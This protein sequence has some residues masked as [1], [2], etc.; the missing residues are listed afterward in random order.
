MK[1]IADSELIINS[2]GAIYHLD[3]RPEEI[4]T[5]IIVVGDPDRVKKVSRYFDSL[6]YKAQHR[7]FITHTGYV[8]KKR[9]SVISTGIGPDNIDIVLNEIDALHNIDFT[10]RLI[11]EKLT[12]VNI[13][14]MGTSGSLQKEI[15]VDS[16]VASTHGLGVDNLL[17]FYRMEINEEE[18][19]LIHAFTTHTQMH[20]SLSQ[21]YISS[22]S[23][24]LLKNFVDGF[25]RGITVTCPGFYGPQGRILRLGL[26]NPELIDRLTQ[27]QF[28][29]HKIS[30]FEMETSAIYG[31]GKLLGHHCL[32]LNAIVA[33]RI[34]KTFSK[35]GNAA[36][37]NLIEKGLGI[38]ASL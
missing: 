8:G 11:K 16:L 21:P 3:L 18:K 23:V 25:Y 33:N 12:S 22:G 26:N 7:E 9:I 28:G 36:V 6:E 5:T 1:P 17:H 35:D 2:R 24:S 29:N 38:I 31:L 14:R 4:A 34:S 27:F 32:S 15:P 10:T 13:I 20:N 19:Q 37:E 30:N